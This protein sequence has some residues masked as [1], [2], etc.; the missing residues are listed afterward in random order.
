MTDSRFFRRAGPFRLEQVAHTVGAKL[1]DRAMA[2]FL[3]SDVA[4]LE[5]AGSEDVSV[6][7]D[8]KYAADFASTQAGV[9]ITERSLSRHEHNG[10]WLLLVAN[11]R[12][13]FA[14]IGHMFYPPDRPVAGAGPHTQVHP[15][16]K[17]GQGT[18]I[19][20]GAVIGAY[21]E[22]GAR[23]S[24]GYNAVIG[25]GVAIGED[26]VIGAGCVIGHALI[27]ARVVFDPNVTVG[28]A[29]F[30]FVPCLTGLLRVPQLG[31]VVIEDDV[32][33]GANCTVDRGAIGDTVIGAGSVFDNMVHVAHNVKI[34]HHCVV[35]GQSGI[36]GSSVIGPGVTIGGQVAIADHLTVG[37]G[38]R[39][40]GKSG[41][42]RDIAEGETVGG[43]PAM[44]IRQW[45]RQT[46]AVKKLAERKGH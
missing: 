7:C 33:F 32:Q 15:T 38:A 9:V 27:G 36:A 14:Q 37:A 12:L 17:I 26:C 22:I 45:H 19:G 20:C 34:G 18:Q 25:E 41:V 40:A 3:L 13:A 2:D 6:F 10:T 21:A 23:S 43:C 8:A 46:A 35:A 42:M 1:C 44:P 31:R 4:A 11:P 5:N 24:I 29:G 16:A 30:S 28:S 39:I